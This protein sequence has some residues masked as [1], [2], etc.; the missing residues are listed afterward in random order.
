MISSIEIDSTPDIVGHDLA[1][2]EANN[3][4]Q[5]QLEVLIDAYQTCSVSVVDFTANASIDFEVV[6]AAS[7]SVTRC[8]QPIR[9]VRTPWEARKLPLRRSVQRYS[10]VRLALEFFLGLSNGDGSAEADKVAGE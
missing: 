5:G 2:V 1:K 10:K 7:H 3:L 6:T 8:K 4:T 9:R